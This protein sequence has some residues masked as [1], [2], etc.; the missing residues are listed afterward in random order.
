MFFTLIA[1]TIVS[2]L[3]V[4]V[5]K[6]VGFVKD[7][8]SSTIRT[9]AI[10]G[11][12]SDVESSYL[13]LAARTAAYKALQATTAYM[14]ATGQYLSN[15]E[16]DLGAAMLNGTVGS[17]VVMA[18]STLRNFSSQ[19]EAFASSIY[20]TNLRITLHSGRMNQSTPGEILI[21][22]N[23]SFVATADVGNWTRDNLLTKISIEGFLDPQYLVRSGGA[24]KQQIRLS[25]P[26]SEQW[27]ISGLNGL[28]SSGNYTR[29]EGS[30]SPSFLG[31]FRSSPPVSPCCG[32]ESTINPAK[33]SPSS[34]Q[35]SYADYQ[36]WQSS[37][38]CSDLYTISG[39]G[40]SHA[41]FKLDLEHAVKYNVTDYAQP[42]TCP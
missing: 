3:L 21:T 4:M 39:G 7:S 22:V 25:T 6:S 2:I 37:E 38:E 16:N 15:P 8:G 1:L 18:N 11:F 13:P 32:I 42:L 5:S 17:R 9:K 12:L 19:I 35:E 24:Y 29:F 26:F 27:N 23:V 41:N 14:N 36:F 40:F 20:S 34:Q 31:R 28:V 10:D 30:A 33:V